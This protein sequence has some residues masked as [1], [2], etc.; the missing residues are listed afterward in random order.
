VEE[1]GGAEGQSRDQCPGRPHLKQ[2]VG[3]AA[4]MVGKGGDGIGD[5]GRRGELPISC[6]LSAGTTCVGAI[7]PNVS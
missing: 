1:D 3:A 7:S 5:H 6:F 2:P 4:A